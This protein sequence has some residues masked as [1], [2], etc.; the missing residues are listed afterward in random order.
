MVAIWSLFSQGV[1]PG[2]DQVKISNVQPDASGSFS[3]EATTAAN[4]TVKYS[5]SFSAAT[6]VLSLEL[7]AL[8][9]IHQIGQR[10]MNSHPIQQLKALN[11]WE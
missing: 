6:G 1:V 11:V 5:G 2:E 10:L 9:Q 3:G 8:W 7:N 4:N